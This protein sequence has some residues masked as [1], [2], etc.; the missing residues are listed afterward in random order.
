MIRGFG[1][2]H[3]I[4]LGA[5]MSG[6]YDTAMVTPYYGEFCSVFFH[7]RCLGSASVYA[8]DIW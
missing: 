1:R 5:R 2:E 8:V 6:F 3:R 4:V 7:L